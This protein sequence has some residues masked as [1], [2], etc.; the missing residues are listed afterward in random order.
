VSANAACE[1][2]SGQPS[3]QNTIAAPT[4][5]APQQADVTDAGQQFTHEFPAYS[6]S[7]MRL[8]VK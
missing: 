5:V 3:D 2:L 1:V 6:V 7:V 8:N 4:K